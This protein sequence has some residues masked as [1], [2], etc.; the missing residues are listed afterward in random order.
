[1][2]GNRR[3]ARNLP[4]PAGYVNHASLASRPSGA[5]AGG[6][7]RLPL[8]PREPAPGRKDMDVRGQLRARLQP[9]R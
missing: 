3:V 6:R 5:I 7:Q 4:S 9:N 2:N 8:Q 1:M